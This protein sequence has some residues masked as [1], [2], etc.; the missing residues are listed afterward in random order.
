MPRDES[1]M[2]EMERAEHVVLE[3]KARTMVEEFAA[4][5]CWCIVADAIAM[6][7]KMK[8]VIRAATGEDVD[9]GDMQI[10]GVASGPA[11]IRAFDKAAGRQ[12]KK[13]APPV[14]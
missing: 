8:S 13:P 5:Q 9:V 6:V 12:P 1:H 11:L 4:E 10:G 2:N 3:A 7:S 14:S